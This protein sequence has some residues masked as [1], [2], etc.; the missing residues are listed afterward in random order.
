MPAHTQEVKYHPRFKIVAWLDS[1]P[2]AHKV[3]Q[4]K[5]T[6]GNLKYPI[7]Q[8]DSDEVLSKGNFDVM[9]SGKKTATVHYNLIF[10]TFKTHYMVGLSDFVIEQN[11]RKTNLESTGK[12][13]QRWTSTINKQ[14]PKILDPIKG[15]LSLIDDGVIPQK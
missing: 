6:L 14:V 5:F 11:G 7:V 4:I 3:W 2:Q 10:K 12:A 9:E 1:V 15:A 13:K 8:A